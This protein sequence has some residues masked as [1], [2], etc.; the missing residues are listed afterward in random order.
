MQQENQ[1]RWRKLWSEWARPLLISALVLGSFR[2]AG[3]DWNDVPT[4]SMEPTVVPGDRVFVNKL[5]Y[6]LKVPFTTLRISEWSAPRRGDIVVLYSPADGRRL[7]KRVVALP[8]DTLEVK[9]HRLTVNGVA[10]TYIRRADGSVHETLDGRTHAVSVSSPSGPGAF[11]SPIVLPA[12]QYFV[13]G[14]HRDNS[15]DSRFFGPVEGSQ[16]V[17]RATAVVLS[18]DRDHHYVPRWG[19]FFTG[20]Q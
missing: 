5:A 6:D 20:L 12:G 14:D 2:S 9:N 11:L 7:L 16:I 18:V 3:A 17:G 1:G 4:G 13:M 8:G 19:R 15:F 10:A